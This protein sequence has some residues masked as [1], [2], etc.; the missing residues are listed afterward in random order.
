MHKIVYFVTLEYQ[1]F[2]KQLETA[3]WSHHCP[4][5]RFRDSS[6]LAVSGRRV[7]EGGVGIGGAS[8][9]RL[10]YRNRLRD[11]TTGSEEEYEGFVSGS[12]PREGS[13]LS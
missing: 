3:A 1:R 6:W 9:W 2:R 10:N 12:Q 7:A 13:I 4:T 11:L 5:E 8:A